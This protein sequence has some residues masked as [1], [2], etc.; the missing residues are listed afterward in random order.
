MVQTISSRPVA[1]RRDAIGVENPS[2][3]S[4]P[5]RRPS[6]NLSLHPASFAKTGRKRAL[7]IGCKYE[8]DR[9]WPELQLPHEDI[10]KVHAMLTSTLSGF[11]LLLVY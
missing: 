2:L 9:Y 3:V 8:N 4:A 1:K 11:L 6:N 7:L 10:M 5:E